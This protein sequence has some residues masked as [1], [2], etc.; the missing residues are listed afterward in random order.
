MNIVV[1]FL[2][3]FLRI[4]TASGDRLASLE[5]WKVIDGARLPASGTDAR[6]KTEQAFV[7]LASGVYKWWQ[8]SFLIS[9][10]SFPKAQTVMLKISCISLVRCN[11][12]MKSHEM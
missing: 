1:S 8:D 10:I 4:A 5:E 12:I 6:M 3:G 7:V 11:N 9:Y 2:E